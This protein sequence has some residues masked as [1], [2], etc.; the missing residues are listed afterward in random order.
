MEKREKGTNAL[1]LDLLLDAFFVSPIMNP[2][3]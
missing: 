3:P 1:S 2:I